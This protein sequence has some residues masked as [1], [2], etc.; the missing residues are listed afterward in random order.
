MDN[1]VCSCGAVYCP[2]CGAG[3]DLGYLEGECLHVLGVDSEDFGANAVAFS[4]LALPALPEDR[5]WDDWSEAQKR[6]AFG[7]CFALLEACEEEIGE[8]TLSEGTRYQMLERAI[9]QRLVSGKVVCYEYFGACTSNGCVCITRTPETSLEE[10]AKLTAGL[11]E[12]FRRLY[13]M[14]PQR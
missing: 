3:I 13:R 6:E 10:I 1:C 7:A 8:E 5:E 9:D 12:G 11:E 2:L 14:Q 4:E